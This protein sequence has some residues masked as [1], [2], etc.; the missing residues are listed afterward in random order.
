MALTEQDWKAHQ[1]SKASSVPKSFNE[2]LLKQA[3]V[4]STTLTGTPEWDRYLQ[5]LQVKYQE[6]V[7]ELQTLYEKM[8]TPMTQ[9]QV[10]LSYVAVNVIT[11][12]KRVLEE[13]MALP[14][15]IVQHA[16][17]HGLVSHHD[18]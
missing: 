14:K 18:Q 4:E 3:A 5:R 2:A 15:E 16:A 1:A 12:R 9:E 17:D 13:C 7:R 8:A 10:F 11:E 6:A